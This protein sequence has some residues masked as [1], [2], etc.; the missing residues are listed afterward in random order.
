MLLRILLVVVAVLA[1]A[2]LFQKISPAAAERAVRRREAWRLAVRKTAYSLGALAFL[3]AAGFG[4][5][6][7]LRFDDRT[8]WALAAVATPLAGWLAYLSHRT[9]RR[10]R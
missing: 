8:A 2:S 9:G 4:A 3:L 7:A 1:I 10:F 5:W 6:H